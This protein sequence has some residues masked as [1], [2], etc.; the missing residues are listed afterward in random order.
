[1]ATFIKK[2]TKFAIF[3]VVS[4]KL[5]QFS[6]YVH[7]N[8]QGQTNS[9]SLNSNKIFEIFEILYIHYWPIRRLLTT[10]KAHSN[11]S[12]DNFKFRLTSIAV[13]TEKRWE[14]K[15]TVRVLFGRVMINMRLVIIAFIRDVPS[16]PNFNRILDN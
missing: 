16:G 13:L 1:M 8:R 10:D 7:H 2:T 5:E 11:G 15:L 3:S 6:S 12:W 14:K 4:W 9:W